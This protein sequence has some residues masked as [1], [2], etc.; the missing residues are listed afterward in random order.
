MIVTVLCFLLGVIYSQ[1]LAELPNAYQ[2]SVLVILMVGLSVVKYWRLMIFVIGMLWSIGYSMMG[3]SETLPQALEGKD[4]EVEGYIDSLPAVKQNR[5][6]F[7]FVLKRTQEDMPQKIRLSW[8]YPQQTIKAGQYWRLTVRL[9]KPRGRFNPGGFDYE[10]WLFSRGIGAVGYVRDHPEPELLS[11]YGKQSLSAWRQSLVDRM[12]ARLG[13]SPSLAFIKALTIGERSSLTQAQWDVF[14]KTGTA[15]LVAISGLHVG[16]VA[17][18]IYLLVLK[19]WIY[20]GILSFSPQKA[21][22]IGAL[23]AAFCYAALAGFAL[24]TQRALIM[25]TVG[26]LAVYWQRQ[27]TPLHAV[28][29]ALFAVLI[30]DPLSVHSASFWLSFSAVL[31]IIYTMAG[32]L[33]GIGYWRSLIRVDWVVSVGLTPIIMLNFQQIAFVAPLANLVAVPVISLLVAPSCL[34]AVMMMPVFPVLSSGL[35]GLAD[36]VLEKLWLFLS[37]CADWSWASATTAQP[38]IYAVVFALAGVF[39]LLSPKGTPCRYLSVLMFLPLVFVD[40]D[41]PG[42]GEISMTLLD[43]GQ[44]LATV[45]ETQNHTLVFDTGAKFSDD[46]DMGKAV[47]LPFLRFQGIDNIDVLLIS[48]GDNDH[49]GGAESVLQGMS[50]EKVISS[51]T[52]MKNSHQSMTCQS[53]F[54]WN[55]DEVQFSLLS[56]PQQDYFS[57]ENDNSCVLKISNG[58]FSFLL[59]GDI[60]KPAEQWMLQQYGGTLA[61]DVLIAPHHGSKTSSGLAFLQ[62]VDPEVALIPA[63]YRNRFAFPHRQVLDRYRQLEID[64]LNIAEEGAIIVKTD[65]EALLLESSRETHKKYWFG[66]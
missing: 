3:M 13:D 25:I 19:A 56:P 24:P 54:R 14:R 21:A 29:M 63:G 23:F 7:D 30:I 9:R 10:M 62:Q 38:P 49:I 22:V 27:L 12:N 5:T 28:S 35:F 50:V 34:F 1:N 15:H 65:R 41:K 32:R 26:L 39:L 47:V 8:Y 55:W 61:S 33:R 36:W 43:V 59:T 53:G 31:L 60:E 18:L 52:A 20:T 17:G 37:V 4:F 16:F 42:R 45:V 40:V 58:R 66:R 64:W 48:H 11:Q 6:T 2:M 57:D 51:V 46:F 44:G